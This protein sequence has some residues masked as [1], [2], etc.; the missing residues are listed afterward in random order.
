[1]VGE[2]RER[3]KLSEQST[4]VKHLTGIFWRLESMINILSS[5]LLESFRSSSS[6]SGSCKKCSLSI[7]H[8]TFCTCADRND[9][10]K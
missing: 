10:I 5:E 9:K 1:M 7:L 4:N 6:K 8:W 2:E 3:D